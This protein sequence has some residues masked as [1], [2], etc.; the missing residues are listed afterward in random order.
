MQTGRS[1]NLRN[2][3]VAELLL[4][5]IAK[6][7]S[8]LSI[9]RGRCKVLDSLHVLTGDTLETVRVALLDS[10][11]QAH[12]LLI[13]VQRGVVETTLSRCAVRITGSWVSGSHRS[14]GA[15]RLTTTA[16]VAN[17]FAKL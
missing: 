4:L 6:H 7:G 15:I 14:D 3:V 5:L 2:K 16:H 9:C 11:E 8:R 17:I 13:V 10:V 1:R 12:L